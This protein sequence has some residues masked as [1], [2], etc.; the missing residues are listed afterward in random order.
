MGAESNASKH[1]GTVAVLGTGRVGGALGPRFASLGY[2]VVYGSRTPNDDRVKALVAKTGG[3]ASAASQSEAASRADIVVLA[4]PWK[5]AD[6]VLAEVG[7]LDGK[8]VIDATNALGVNAEGRMEMVVD[9]SAGEVLQERLPN[10][11]IVKAFNTIGYHIMADPKKA[12]G[13]VTVPIVGND[14]DAKARVMGMV[15]DLGFH[16]IDLGPIVHAR[17]LEGMAVLYMVP[18]MSGRSDEAFEFYL[19]HPN[20]DVLTGNVRPAQ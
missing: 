8:L 17:H 6:A 11:H 10:A 2:D 1:T 4:I 7:T 12:G 18:L 5:A 15:R 9:T 3:G 13:T 19:R 14:A 20:K 16:T